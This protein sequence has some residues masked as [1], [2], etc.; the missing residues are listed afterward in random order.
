M[1]K[2]RKERSDEEKL[3][4]TEIEVAGSKRTTGRPLLSV[5]CPAASSPETSLSETQ[6]EQCATAASFFLPSFLPTSLPCLAGLLGSQASRT[7][8]KNKPRKGMELQCQLMR[9]AGR[10]AVS[11]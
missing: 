10:D 8:H 4:R 11:G 6:E 9:S 5:S 7:R 2:N 1:V 3:E